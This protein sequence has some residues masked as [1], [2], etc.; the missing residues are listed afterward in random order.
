MKGVATI[1]FKSF[2]LTRTA[3]YKSLIT[4]VEDFNRI[5]STHKVDLIIVL[6]VLNEFALLIIDY[7]KLPSIFYSATISVPWF[8]S[9]MN[10]KQNYV[11]V[12]AFGTDFIIRMSS[13]E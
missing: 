9:S 13:K 11:Y 8:I 10:A 12:P 5:V 6:T 3:A 7:L 1:L 4:A 2:R